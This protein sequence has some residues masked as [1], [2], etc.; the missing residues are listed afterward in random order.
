[1]G[2]VLDWLKPDDSAVRDAQAAEEQRRAEIEAAQKRIEEIFSSPERLAQYQAFEE[3]TRGYLTGEL[4]RQHD[5]TGRNLKFALARSG[6]TS[7]SV[8]A[9]KNRKLA[10]D[11]MKNL[12][13]IE[14]QSVRAGADLRSADQQT[15]WSLFS[16][17][18]GGLDATTAEQNAAQSMRQN[19]SIAEAEAYQRLTNDLFGDFASLF[20]TSR[21][22]AGER[23]AA[24]DLNTTYG[25][26]PH[27][28]APVAGAAQSTVPS[29]AGFGMGR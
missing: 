26:R 19:S 25:V 27:Q 11:Y 22:E 4:D 13:G 17:I 16:Q 1:M 2:F 15:K 9:D 12:L 24:F 3:A 20:K 18:L 29:F 7:G 23:R 21:E 5:I 14:R 10:E 28:I 6:L 8:D